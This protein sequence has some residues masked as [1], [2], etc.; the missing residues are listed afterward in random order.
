[1][2]E[3]SRFLGIVIA[4]YYR[5]HGKPHF[6][7][8]YGD[9]RITVEIE[10]GTVNGYFPPRALRHVLEWCELHKQ[11]LL[12]DWNLAIQRKPLKKITPLE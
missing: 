11:E 10:T 7:A 2:P 12:D 5:E 1:M 4:I 8:E 3:I 6:H 9:Y